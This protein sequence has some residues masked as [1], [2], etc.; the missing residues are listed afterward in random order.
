MINRYFAI[1]ALSG[2]A[3]LAAC[4][5]VDEQ[6]RHGVYMARYD[7]IEQRMPESVLWAHCTRTERERCLA[8]PSDPNIHRCS[9][10]EWAARRP[11]PLK[12]AMIRLEGDTWRWI[13][14]DTPSCSITVLE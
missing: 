4:A 12:R 2:V 7:W 3:L 9:Y 11:W 13:E 6:S 14:G 1:I 5:T 8:M 10:R